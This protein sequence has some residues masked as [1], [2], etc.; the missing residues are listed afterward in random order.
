FILN[1]PIRN[2]PPARQKR[3]LARSQAAL[4]PISRAP[5][6]GTLAVPQL[7]AQLEREP[8][9]EGAETSRKVKFI[10]GSSL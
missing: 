7:R 2:L 1:T 10:L 9:V 4:T 5:L 8:I 3:S 6:D